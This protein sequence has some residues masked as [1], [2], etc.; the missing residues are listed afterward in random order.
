MK[1]K[2][3]LGVNPRAERQQEDLLEFAKQIIKLYEK[4][5]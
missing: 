5:N 1:S 2:L 4:G 3:M